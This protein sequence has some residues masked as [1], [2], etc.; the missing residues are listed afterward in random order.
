M[1]YAFIKGLERIVEGTGS[2]CFGVSFTVLSVTGDKQIPDAKR[3]SFHYAAVISIKPSLS[4]LQNPNPPRVEAD[5][6]HFH[7]GKHL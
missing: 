5:L 1:F 7:N 6:P 3:D 4:S 2:R